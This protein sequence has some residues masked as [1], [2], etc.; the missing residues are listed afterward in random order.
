MNNKNDCKVLLDRTDKCACKESSGVE[1]VNHDLMWHDADV[2][3]IDC[4]KFVRYY[5][6]G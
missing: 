4:H 3:C 1:I 5:D 6:A 2:V